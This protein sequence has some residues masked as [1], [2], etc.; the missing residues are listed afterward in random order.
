[1]GYKQKF[2]DGRFLIGKW[3][4][5]KKSFKNTEKIGWSIY[6]GKNKGQ[7]TLKWFRLHKFKYIF[8]IPLLGILKRYLKPVKIID[9]PQN[10]NFIMFNEVFER[11]ITDWTLCYING[12]NVHQGSINSEQ[13]NNDIN[14]PSQKILRDM[15]LVLFQFIEKDTAYREFFNILVYNM[16][17][18]GN[19]MY[20]GEKVQHLMYNRDVDMD[21]QYRSW[22]KN[23]PSLLHKIRK[24]WLK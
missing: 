9:D 24:K 8:L 13:L 20:N 15:K 7:Q 6:S 1:L 11:S 18:F 14:G 17:L 19:E 10:R 12:N 4:K 22:W 3:S 2:S 5:D 23:Q 16:A 21:L